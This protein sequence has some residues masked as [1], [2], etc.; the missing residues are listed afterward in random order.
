MHQKARARQESTPD[1]SPEP[2]SPAWK[3]YLNKLTKKAADAERLQK[4]RDAQL[5]QFREARKQ[6]EEVGDSWSLVQYRHVNWMKLCEDQ[7]EGNHVNVVEIK[8]SFL[9]M[10]DHFSWKGAYR[11][12]EAIRPDDAR[13]FAAAYPLDD[14]AVGLADMRDTEGGV[15]G[16]THEELGAR[17]GVPPQD[18]IRT[19]SSA[20]VYLK[21][22]YLGDTP[23][24]YSTLEGSVHSGDAVPMAHVSH[25]CD[26]TT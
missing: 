9:R 10:I 20:T 23:P 13:I 14:D 18:V 6:R 11:E 25:R 22:I 1:S 7:R 16:F 5:L 3:A 19:L 17:L 15:Q 21:A 2:Q 26:S 12:L 24:L 8:P 4:N